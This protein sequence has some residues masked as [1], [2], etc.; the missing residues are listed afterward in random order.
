MMK[1]AGEQA[2][3]DAER[4]RVIASYGSQGKPINKIVKGV[5]TINELNNPLLLGDWGG[6]KQSFNRKGMR[7]SNLNL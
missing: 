3:S 6:P 2:A 1:Q 4:N 7:I 5:R